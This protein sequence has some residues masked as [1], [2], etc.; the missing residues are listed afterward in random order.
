MQLKPSIPLNIGE[1]RQA[2]IYLVGCGGI[3][4]YLAQRLTRLTGHARQMGI[5]IN[6][7]FIDPD[8]VERKNLWRQLFV[9][10]EV[11]QYKAE[12]LAA[13]YARGFGLPIQFYNEPLHPNHIDGRQRYRDGWLH[14]IIG[15]VD[16]TSARADIQSIVEGWSGRMWWLDCGN[17]DHSGQVIIGNRADL[18]APEISP[19]GFC[20]GLPLPGIVMPELITRPGQTVGPSCA[21]DALINVQGL[22]VNETVAGFAAHYLYRLL[23]LNDLDTRITYFN[24]QAGN[25]RSEYIHKS[26]QN[27]EEK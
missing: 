27:T 15:A 23:I 14:L 7:T 20:T 9:E 19:L 11:G 4:S 17:H 1:P 25:A 3:G 8:K 18:T 24:L 21:D 26:T 10:S 2:N 16:N 13:R 6:L 12:A 22:M 5:A